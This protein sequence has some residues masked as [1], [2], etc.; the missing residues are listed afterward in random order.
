LLDVERSADPLTHRTGRISDMGHASSSITSHARHTTPSDPHAS[1]RSGTSTSR[2]EFAALEFEMFSETLR[3]DLAPA[4]LLEQILVQHVIIASWRMNGVV[5]EETRRTLS[6]EAVD[7]IG[8]ESQSANAALDSALAL[9]AM[10]RETRNPHWGRADHPAS[11]VVHEPDAEDYESD[12]SLRFDP[13]SSDLSNEWPYIADQFEESDDDDIVPEDSEDD[14]DIPVHWQDR[15]VFD[16]NVSETSPVVKGTWVT[17]SHVV[18]LIVDGW[19]WSDILRAHPE[20]TE[21][22]VRTCLAYTAE[23]DDRGD[24]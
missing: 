20:L 12:R 18:S 13:R 2:T 8:A 4:S 19:T 16:D 24:Y 15:L 9:F 17:V 11:V 22:D 21:D 6:G 7:S 1:V 23:Q 10:A 3:Q 14:S 5:L